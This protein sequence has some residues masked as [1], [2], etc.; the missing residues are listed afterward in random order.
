MESLNIKECISGNM[1]NYFEQKKIET[2]IDI[3]NKKIAAE[4]SPL[5]DAISKMAGEI[6]ELRSKLNSREAVAARQPAYQNYT[7]EPPASARPPVYQNY[8]SEP[9][10]PEPRRTNS[11]PIKPRFGDYQPEDVSV[12][13]MFYFGR[14]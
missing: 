6:A 10:A 13:K 1:D 2:L 3:N 12:T 9:A 11:E 8:T 5:K 7:S 4:L 14:K